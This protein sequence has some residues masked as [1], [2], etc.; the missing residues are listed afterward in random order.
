MEKMTQVTNK[1][2]DFINNID[3]RNALIERLDELDRVFLVNA[4]YSTVFGALAAIEGI[5]KHI[6]SIYR[7]EIRISSSY[8]K[9]SKGNKKRFG[10]LTLNELYVELT[11]LG[12][13]P[14]IPGYED[15]YN[16]FRNYR[17]FIHPQAQ[18]SKGWEIELGQS[19][20]AIGLLNATIQKL[21]KNLFIGKHI[22]EKVAGAPDYGP[23]EGLHLK[24]GDTPHNSFLILKQS[25]AQKVFITFELELPQGSLL[26]FVFNYEN[27]GR[28]KM[29]RLDNRIHQFYPNAVLNSYQKYS[30]NVNLLANPQ[31]PPDI[32]L[33]PVEIE[34]DFSKKQ[35]E[36]LADN[37]VYTFAD[38][39]GDEKKLFYEIQEDKR[40]GF[41]NE[42][43]PAR[44][45]N[46]KIDMD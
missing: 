1:Q 16:L 37:I 43:G 17:N 7:D 14:H 15:L 12:I 29:L 8:P 2:L 39:V 38:L 36:F 11:N 40:V 20:M 5:F 41:F 46:I 13:L 21:D 45:S 32:E 42:V 27:D 19:Q 6:A 25:I 35:F 28:F 9:T 33:F 18:V 10:Y 24:E 23:V 34:I 4:N 31:K 3:L 44:L 30:W 22:F 26:N